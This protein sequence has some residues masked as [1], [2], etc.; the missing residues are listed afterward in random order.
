[1]DEEIKG[2]E[3]QKVRENKASVQGSLPVLTEL[4]QVVNEGEGR[5]HASASSMGCL[6]RGNR[7]G[8]RVTDSE[9][10]RAS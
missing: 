2:F 10:R 6:P 1:M 5:A 8:E 7:A 3:E 9:R 4:E